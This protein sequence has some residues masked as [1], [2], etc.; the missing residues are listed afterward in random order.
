MIARDLVQ[1]GQGGLSVSPDDP[2]N[3]P[4][5]RRPT[6][7]Q[8]TGKDPVWMIEEVDLGS[9][10]RYRFDPLNRC[11]GFIEPS[12]PAI[13]Q[14]YQTAIEQMQRLWQKVISPVSGSSCDVS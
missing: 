14:K 7:F 3:L 11:H 12:R 5:H 10:L 13:L 4:A 1:S 8:G 2:M 6:E 9:D